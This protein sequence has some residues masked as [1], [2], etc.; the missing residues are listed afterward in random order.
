MTK[1]SAPIDAVDRQIGAAV[2]TLRMHRG[3]TLRACAELCGNS[4]EWLRLIESGRRPLDRLSTVI[5]LG[6]ALGVDDLAVLLGPRLRRLRGT[7]H[8]SAHVQH[9]AVPVLQRLLSTPTYPQETTRDLDTEPERIRRRLSLA[10]SAWHRFDRPYTALGLVVPDLLRDAL[11]LHR[12]SPATGRRLTW[13]LLSE[14]FQMAQRFLYCVGEPHLAA[15][16]ADRAMVAAEE[17]DDPALIAVSAWS[18]AMAAL[19]RA[20]ADEAH[21]IAR[22]ATTHLRPLLATSPA[23][24]STWGAL[25]LFD[26]IAQARLRRPASAWHSWSIAQQA[27]DTLGPEHHHPL[28][29]FGCANVA[30]YAV[31]IN[32]ETG[33]AANAIQSASRIDLNTI[34]STNRRAQHLI[35]LAHG[36][37]RRSNIDA[38]LTALLA[39]EQQSGE[40]IAFNPAASAAITEIVEGTK[41]P[42]RAALDLAT[43]VLKGKT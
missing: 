15:R 10:W 24:M 13:Q 39:S 5:T 38:A 18:S 34:P 42:P 21:A 17:T 25:H 20:E 7:L 32:V 9:E 41:R 12:A 16:A 3:L 14:A 31:A 11:A 22:D 36:H 37:L 33:Q 28:T 26:A 43:R 35:D 6:I 4:E 27:A 40:P 23:A 30:I 8:D 1:T 29:M 19:G 2:R